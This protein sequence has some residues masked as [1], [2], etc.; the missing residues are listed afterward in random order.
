M[1]TL[2][3]GI[4]IIVSATFNSFQAKKLPIEWST[5]NGKWE[6]I[7]VVL[8][9]GKDTT[10]V[11]T[12]FKPYFSTYNSDFKYKEEYPITGTSTTAIGQYKIDK[13]KNCINFSEL[14]WTTK[15][16]GGKVAVPDVVYK[17]GKQELYV[18]SLSLD[19]IVLL[20]KYIPQSE[21][22]GDYIFY[23]KKIK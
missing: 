1:K 2:T 13:T 23:M 7:K 18:L 17:A 9:K 19:K 12:Q 22:Q 21:A 20:Q 3:L 8:I 6:C 14:V 5:L 4:L 16:S 15:Y 10:D 11:S